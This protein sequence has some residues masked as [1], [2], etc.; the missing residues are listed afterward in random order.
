MAMTE[1]MA[2][3][4]LARLCQWIGGITPDDVASVMAEVRALPDPAA[5]A[6]LSF[7]TSAKAIGDPVETC[8]QGVKLCPVLVVLTLGGEPWG[9]GFRGAERVF[10][11]LPATRP[12][13]LPALLVT[14]A[15]E[16]TRYAEKRAAERPR[17]TYNK[18][19]RDKD[20]AAV[21]A[22][23]RGLRAIAARLTAKGGTP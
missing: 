9:P 21:Q 4:Q 18:D 19:A 1:E 12:N 10:V 2:R 8:I 3:D 14:Y 11:R 17:A 6:V 16:L 5:N 13:V 7:D 15:D 20:V 22:A 23:V